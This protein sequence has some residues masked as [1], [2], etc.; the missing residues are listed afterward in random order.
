MFKSGSV[1]IEKCKDDSGNVVI[2][3]KEQQTPAI[4][5]VE[6]QKPDAPAVADDSPRERHLEYHMGATYES[7]NVLIEIC[8]R[9]LPQLV[10]DVEINAGVQTL[11]TMTEGV[12]E[13]MEP[14]VKKYGENKDFGKGVSTALRDAVFPKSSKGAGAYESLVAL[15]GLFMYLSHLEIHLTALTPASQALWD[16]DFTD[17]VAFAQAQIGRQQTWV[18]VQIKTRSPQ[19]LLVPRKP[20]PEGFLKGQRIG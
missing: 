7:I 11:R 14:Q 16:G 13:Q 19:V 5:K 10:H 1:R 18:N 8:D 3:A 17:A 9:L 15:Q 20:L 6:E 12:R 2:H 4:H